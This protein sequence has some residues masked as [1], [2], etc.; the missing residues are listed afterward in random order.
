DRIVETDVA[1]ALIA[2][3]AAEAQLGDLE[4][5]LTRRLR[6]EPGAHAFLEATIK[7]AWPNLRK[8]LAAYLGLAVFPGEPGA[9]LQIREAVEDLDRVTQHVM[10]AHDLSRG[11][12]EELN[13]AI[14]EGVTRLRTGI[15]AA[16]D[17]N[18]DI[19]RSVASRVRN[20]QRL[21]LPLALL[22]NLI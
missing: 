20:V 18:A 6:S 11:A 14:E 9:Q 2:L 16:V 10:R 7:D 3:E 19:E 15:R 17:V 5:V 12:A 8:H 13:R 21:Y 1:P 4:H 22:L